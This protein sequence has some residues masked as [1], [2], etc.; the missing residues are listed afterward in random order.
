MNI[1]RSY[2]YIYIHAHT[3]KDISKNI[4]IC[5]T[6]VTTIKLGEAL[7]SKAYPILEKCSLGENFN[8]PGL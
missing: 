1:T 2:I 5:T 3:L 4:Y 6:L 8:K 7:G